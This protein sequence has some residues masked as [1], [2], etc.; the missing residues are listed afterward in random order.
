MLDSDD[1]LEGLDPEQRAVA[2]APLGPVVVRAGAG[3]GKTRA[4]THRIAYLVHAGL[5]PAEQI[6]ALTFTTRAAGELAIRLRALGVPGVQARTFHSAALRQLNHFWPHEVGGAMPTVTPSKSALVTAA[7]RRLGV[8]ANAAT[9][10]DIAGEIEWAKS[11]VMTPTQYAQNA[12]DR[13]APLTQVP[14]EQVF[15]AYEDEKLA[16]GQIDFEDVLLLATALMEE[17]GSAAEEVQ[18]RYRHYIVDEYQDVSPLQER[19]LS[20]WLGDSRSLTVVGDAAQTIYSFAG[21]TAQF[22]DSFSRRFP[23]AQSF[24]LFRDYRSTSEVVAVANALL[25]APQWQGASAAVRLEAQRGSGPLPRLLPS[26]PD[27][28]AGDV[29]RRIQEQQQA[30]T[31]LSDIAV[32]FRTNAQSATI[33]EALAQADIA[34]TVRGSERFFDRA[35]IKRAMTL[36][37]GAARAGV[38]TESPDAVL[39]DIVRALEA[40]GWSPSQEAAARSGALGPAARE[41]WEA[42]AA[43]VSAARDLVQT[44]PSMTVVGVYAALEKRANDHHGSAVEGVTLATLHAAKGLEWKCVHLI[45]LNEGLMP[46]VHART[47]EHIDEERRLLYVGITRAQSDLL[48]SWDAQKPRS[49]FLSDIETAVASS[50][51]TSPATSPAAD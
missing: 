25:L 13:A 19:L 43:L 46:L 18:Q 42:V 26:G 5:V 27:G 16:R 14:F 31:A 38:T 11:M 48:L 3:T 15:A 44:D 30:G 35:D 1:V 29:A 23:T 2:C 28:E 6:M 4:I 21:A 22:L 33:E 50:S 49:R 51:A 41:S 47:Q 8:S 7:L 34:Y 20:A 24:E 39:D 37:R 12:N 9:I 10:G 17:D 32:L 40:M 45:G 36:I